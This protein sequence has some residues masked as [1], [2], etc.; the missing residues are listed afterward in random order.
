MRKNVKGFSIVE[1]L[2]VM[3]IIVLLLAVLL[4]GMN[5]ARKYAKDLTQRSQFR[6]IEIGLELYSKDND[7][8]YVDSSENGRD[9]APYC[10]AMKLAEVLCGQDGMGFNPASKLNSDDIAGYDEELYPDWPTSFPLYTPIQERSINKRVEYMDKN[11][12]NKMNLVSLS[13]LYLTT[14]VFLSVVNGGPAVI[15]DVYKRFRTQTTLEKVGLPI[16]YYRANQSNLYHD[17][18]DPLNTKNI[19]NYKDNHEL[20]KLGKPDDS[21]FVHPL[22]QDTTELI[23]NGEGQMFYKNTL[24]EKA[25]SIDQPYHCDSY[26][27]ISAGHDGI[28]GNRDDVYNFSR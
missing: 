22:F 18:L 3:S 24:N 7:N 9:N 2:T 8:E 13:E 16:L 19:Y 12:I 1:L 28:Y 27:L 14:G 11:V 15:T 26:I 10:G 4:P 21:A 20:V 6:E 17:L 5:M 25:P 23:Y